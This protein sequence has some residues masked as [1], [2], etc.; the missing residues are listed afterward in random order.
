[1]VVG[2]CGPVDA[3]AGQQM[4]AHGGETPGQR[5]ILGAYWGFLAGTPNGV[6]TRV[7][8]LRGRQCSCAEACPS[9]PAWSSGRAR[10]LQTNAFMETAPFC[11]TFYGMP[12]A[13]ATWTSRPGK[14]R[15]PHPSVL[16]P[17]RLP[18]GSVGCHQPV[19][20]TEGVRS[21]PA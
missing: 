16:C 12:E 15:L 8:T 5:P 17:T 6:R 4:S 13:A 9:H 19:A 20:C 3:E 7:S 18:G 1:V 11:G 14:A 21:G 10:R 2:L